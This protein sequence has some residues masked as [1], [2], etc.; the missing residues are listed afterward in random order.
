VGEVGYSLQRELARLRKERLLS[1]LR[2]NKRENLAS[3]KRIEKEVM[4]EE[5]RVWKTG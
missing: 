3:C 1:Q 5:E 4:N 2:I